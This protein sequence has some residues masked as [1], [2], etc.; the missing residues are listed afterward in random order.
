MPKKRKNLDIDAYL[1]NLEKIH[2]CDLC[3]PYLGEHRCHGT[4]MCPSLAGYEECKI[5]G[6]TASVCRD[7]RRPLGTPLQ[8]R[9]V[10][11]LQLRK[12]LEPRADENA[13]TLSLEPPCIN[14]AFFLKRRRKT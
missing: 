10:A 5:R 8:D 4:V 2:P 6:R 1:E 12:E 3:H 14:M 9:I 11:M 13:S 7:M